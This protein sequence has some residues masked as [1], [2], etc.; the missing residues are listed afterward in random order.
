MEQ[1]A[2]RVL[3]HLFLG[4]ED[5]SRSS[6]SLQEEGVTH[7][8]V[9][10]HLGRPDWG[11]SFLTNPTIL[12]QKHHIL[13]M[14]G[15]PIIHYFEDCV[16]FIEEGLKSG[17]KVLVHCAEGKSRSATIVIA[18]LMKSRSWSFREAH[19]FLRGKRSINVKFEDQLQLWEECGYSLTGD[20][21]AHLAI[22]RICRRIPGCPGGECTHQETEGV[23]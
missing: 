2:T 6:S 9:P 5:S 22:R 10:A 15:F 18:Y 13:D 11:E 8:L 7:I 1:Y 17:G 19:A 12:H 4:S 20:S 16:S 14:A 23:L 3:P 21:D